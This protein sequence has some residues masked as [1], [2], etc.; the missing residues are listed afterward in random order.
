MR[1]T[2][3]PLRK[4]KGTV[5]LSC[6]INIFHFLFPFT[7]NDAKIILITLV[8]IFS[9]VTLNVVPVKKG[10]MGNSLAMC[11]FPYYLPVSSVSS[12]V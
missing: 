8:T 11:H 9:H 7:E 5:N 2:S 10:A 1:L 6:E 3:E 12:S 4:L